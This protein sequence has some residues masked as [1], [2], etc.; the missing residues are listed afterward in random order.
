[1]EPGAVSK[2][3]WIGP[4][5]VA[6]GAGVAGVGAW[7]IVHVRPVAGDVI[8]REV[9]DDHHQLVVR[10]EA[11]GG[12]RAFV[13]LREDEQVKW[14]ALVPRYAGHAGATGLAWGPVAVSVRVVRD[15][16]AELFALS[17]HDSSKLGGMRLAPEHGPTV[18][19]PGS[20]VTLS[21]HVR[22]YEVVAGADWHQLVA[23]DL[24]SGKALWSQELGAAKV[25][26]GGLEG[27][28]VWI[29]QGHGRQGFAVATGERSSTL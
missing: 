20:P 24:R 25:V 5:I 27:G 26:A 6:L 19:E 11:G 8:E 21:D 18:D 3:G 10:A 4:A 28:H 17:M 12:E 22:T 13:E 15:G 1:M 14:Q 2:L 29:D 7:Y 23:I 9:V 16:H